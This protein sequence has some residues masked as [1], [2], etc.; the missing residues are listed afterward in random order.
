[1]LKC[2]SKR[3]YPSMEIAKNTNVR[4]CDGIRADGIFDHVTFDSG[5]YLDSG[6]A[7]ESL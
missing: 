3:G 2:V 6:K 5:T 7:L 4:N 1:L